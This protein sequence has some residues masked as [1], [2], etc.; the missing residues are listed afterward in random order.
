MVT[1]ALESLPALLTRFSRPG[2]NG[3]LYYLLMHYWL[4]MTGTGE[5]A[6]RYPALL[7]GVFGAAATIAIARVLG[8]S[9]AA[10]VTGLFVALSPF[11]VWYSQ[12]AKM[13]G[14]FFG[15]SALLGLFT[16]LLAKRRR[17]GLMFAWAAVA[18]VSLLIH[19]FASL[20]IVTLLSGLIGLSLVRRVRRR[21]IVGQRAAGTGSSPSAIPL[22]AGGAVCVLLIGLAAA[23]AIGWQLDVLR[24]QPPSAYPAMTLAEVV[25]AFA[26]ALVPPDAPALLVVVIALMVAAALAP[27]GRIGLL[28]WWS[29]V[30]PF[31]LYYLVSLRYPVF[32]ERY[33]I[34]LAMPVYVLMGLGATALVK[35][36]PFMPALAALVLLPA[37]LLGTALQTWRPIKSDFRSAAAFVRQ[38]AS[39]D[40]ALL[41]VSPFVEPTFRYYSGSTLT[42]IATPDVDLADDPRAIAQLTSATAGSPRIWLILSEPE[43]F[44]R[45]GAI[46]RWLS[47]RRTVERAASFVGVGVTLYRR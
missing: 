12:D 33:V 16:V 10:G 30:A 36:R 43:H 6:L 19:L 13:Y 40:D 47:A 4:P 15:L 27:G 35:W 38:F 34:F 3:P 41:F 32:T 14:L 2:E 29:L 17:I 26:R 45:T 5:F 28:L 7:S 21:A 8:G 9:T 44:D 46:G 42:T 25:S 37:F 20:W 31:G 1:F 24:N 39:P 22:A 23:P 11:L 18:S